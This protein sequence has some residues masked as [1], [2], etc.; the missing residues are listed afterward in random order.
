MY[1]RNYLLKF[2]NVLTW[3]LAISVNNTWKDPCS[4]YINEVQR[5]WKR[6]CL[7]KH[8]LLDFEPLYSSR[9][10]GECILW[11]RPKKLWLYLCA[12]I[13]FYTLHSPNKYM[14]TL[15]LLFFSL[16]TVCVIFE[17]KSHIGLIIS[18]SYTNNRFLPPK[19]FV[20]ENF[21]WSCHVINQ[22]IVRVC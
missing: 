16:D 7:K 12:K 20:F 19:Y 22:P 13:W 1:C 10:I 11:Q 18:N 14:Y 9:P 21:R 8:W 5:K 4:W 6:I 2:I 17:T 3:D 15:Y